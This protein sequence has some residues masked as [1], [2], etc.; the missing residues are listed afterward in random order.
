MLN[1]LDTLGIKWFKVNTG[2]VLNAC[3]M[4]LLDINEDVMEWLD[5]E[6]LTVTHLYCDMVIIVIFFARIYD[7]KN[8]TISHA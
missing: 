1:E 8:T 3:Q 2:T 5:S 4:G 6:I 7:M